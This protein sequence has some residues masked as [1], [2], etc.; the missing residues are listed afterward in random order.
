MIC[1][2]QHNRNVVRKVVIIVISVVRSDDFK[3]SYDAVAVGATAVAVGS[4]GVYY[5]NSTRRYGALKQSSKVWDKLD[6]VK[7]TRYRQSGSGR[8]RRYY[9]WDYLHN[10]IEVYDRFGKHLGAVDSTTGKFIKAAEAGRSIR[11]K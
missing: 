4:V 9:D 8:N 10:E 7:G 6:K 1:V 2:G 11:I 5:S 3:E